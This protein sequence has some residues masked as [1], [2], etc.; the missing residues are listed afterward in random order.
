ME[1]LSPGARFT[2]P[3]G[4]GPVAIRMNGMA[5]GMIWVNGQSIGRHRMRFVS[6]LG[7]PT[8]SE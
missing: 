6:L 4:K 3:E 7:Q 5:K 2:T 8:Q 1:N